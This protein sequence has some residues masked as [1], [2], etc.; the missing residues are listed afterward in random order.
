[1]LMPPLLWWWSGG[2]GMA[3]VALAQPVRWL[4]MANLT[5]SCKRLQQLIRPCNQWHQKWVETGGKSGRLVTDAGIGN[6]GIDRIQQPA[7]GLDGL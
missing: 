5:A 3:T 6:G 7:M 1:M 2:S 4:S